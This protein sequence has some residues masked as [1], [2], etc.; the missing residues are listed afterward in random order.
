MGINEIIYNIWNCACKLKYKYYFSIYIV[1]DDHEVDFQNAPEV[2]DRPRW[3]VET[4]WKIRWRERKCENYNY[5]IFCVLNILRNV[6]YVARHSNM[7]TQFYDKNLIDVWP[8]W[9]FCI[10]FPFS[11]ILWLRKIKVNWVILSLFLYRMYVKLVLLV[12]AYV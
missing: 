8:K 12:V 6:L 5:I 10:I 4:N 9:E 11:Y 3:K 2:H 7:L 1:P